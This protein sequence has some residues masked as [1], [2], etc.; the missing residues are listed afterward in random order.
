MDNKTV[1]KNEIPTLSLGF[2]YIFDYDTVENIYHYT[3]P[4]GLLGILGED[5]LVFRFT[6]YD[7]VNDTSE[8]KHVLECYTKSCEE[9][10]DTS[11]IDYEFY[12]SIKDITP[13]NKRFLIFNTGQ[14]TIGKESSFEAYLCCFT[15]EQ[16]SLPM[17]NYYVKNGHYQGY[18]IGVNS[19][20]FNELKK[21]SGLDKGFEFKLI[22]VVYNFNKKKK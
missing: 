18:N 6:R 21:D 9:L 5:G 17:W 7:C 14:H 1:D 13:S 22:K 16:D 4:N 12:N 20:V 15:L 11:E 2:S 19:Q 8:G 3:S 10:L